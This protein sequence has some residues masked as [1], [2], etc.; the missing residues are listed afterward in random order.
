MLLHVAASG[1]RVQWQVFQVC[2]G[3]SVDVQAVR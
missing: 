3:P 2:S 1:E